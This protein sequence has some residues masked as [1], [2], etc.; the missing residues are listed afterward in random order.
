MPHTM[1]PLFACGCVQ[2]IEQADQEL[3]ARAQATLFH[4]HDHGLVDTGSAAEFA[5]GE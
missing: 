4:A 3:G 2:G 5:C 1:G